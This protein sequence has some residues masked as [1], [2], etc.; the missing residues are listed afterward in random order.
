MLKLIAAFIMLIDHFAVVFIPQSDPLYFVL[1]TIGRLAMPV[2]AYYIAKG[3]LMTKHFKKYLLRLALMTLGAQIPFA[4]LGFGTYVNTVTLDAFLSELFTSFNI[5]LTFLSAL[6]VL[7]FI[8]KGE[9]PTLPM[10]KRLLYTLGIIGSG[11]LSLFG[12]YSFYGVTMV[13]LFYHFLK[14]KDHFKGSYVY[15]SLGILAI[16]LLFFGVGSLRLQGACVFS[17]L[18]IR[19]V[20]EDGIKMPRY[21]FYWFYPLHM[22]LLIGVKFLMG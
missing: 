6:L 11:M 13:I 7:F 15:L 5:G 17:V 8:Q 21:F 20:Q 10:Q 1:R 22:V 19:Y 9:S 4:L 18:L 16:T 12:D 3:F 14:H 2:F